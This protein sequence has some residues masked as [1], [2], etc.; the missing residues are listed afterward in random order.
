VDDSVTS[1]NAVTDS[2]YITHNVSS[3][4]LVT[5]NA[6]RELHI[7]LHKQEALLVTKCS[8]ELTQGRNCITTT[9][10][11]M[12]ICILMSGG[13]WDSV[14]AAIYLLKPT[15]LTITDCATQPLRNTH[16]L[17]KWRE[18]QGCVLIIFHVDTIAFLIQ[19]NRNQNVRA[20]S[21]RIIVWQRF[22]QRISVVEFDISKTCT[23]HD[24]VRHYKTKHDT[25]WQH[26]KH[27]NVTDLQITKLGKNDDINV[28]DA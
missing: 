9:C 1:L 21:Y 26:C 17:G 16:H 20:D 25:E 28:S 27:S 15:W 13:K 3:V 6:F 11:L 12:S 24:I 19:Y 2:S 22:L 8:H 4:Q 14:A 18:C 23:N 5:R 10:I 7:C